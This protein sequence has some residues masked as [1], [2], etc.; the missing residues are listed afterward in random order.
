M[1]CRMA[2]KC[3]WMGVAMVL[4]E[5]RWCYGCWEQERIAL[6]Q[7][8]P[9]F[10]SSLT[11]QN[12]ADA[13]EGSDCCQ[14]E[15]VEC[16]STTGRVT[17]LSLNNTRDLISGK[18][19]LNASLFLA[20]EELTSLYLMGNLIL[21]CETEGFERLSARLSNL[22]VLDLSYNFFNESI[23]PSLNGFSSLKSL[24][25]GYN[26]FTL[27]I[28][29]QDLPNFENLEDLFLDKISLNNSF[30]QRV[31]VMT[32]LKV[33]SLSGCG[34]TGLLP[35]AQ[36]LCELIN[37]QMLDVS[38]NDLR[39]TLPWCLVNLIS[40]QQLDLSF[41]QFAGNISHS[42]LKNL[43]SLVDLKLSNNHFQ[44]PFSL[45]PFF[46]HSNLRQINGQYNEIYVETELH[47]SPKFQL[48]SILLSG[49]GNCGPFPN[50]LYHQHDLQIVDLSNMTLK[51]SF[52]NWLLTN[53]TRL[54]V[55]H[56]VNNSLSGHLELPFH[57]HINLS[58]LDISNNNFHNHIPLEIGSYF[59]KLIYLNMSKNGF[60]GSIPSSFGN[61]SSLEILD[62]S[63][64]QLS[65]IIPELLAIGCFS[66][67]TLILSNNNLQGHIF[68]EHFNLT[69]LWW[70][71]LDGNNFSGRISNCLSTSSLSILDLRDNHL[72]GR[73]PGWIGNLSYL[74][75]LVISNNHLE[76]PI[77]LEFC[78]LQYLEVLDLSKNNVSGNLPSCFRPSSIIH[79]YLSDNG[80]EGPMTNALS[81]GRFLTT[82]DLSNNRMTGRIPNW[83]GGLPALK[84]LLLKNNNFDGEI[85]LQMCHQFYRLSLIDLS[86]NNLSG[87]IPSCL[88][89]DLS[90]EPP[91]PNDVSFLDP[92]FFPFFEPKRPL[93]F[94]TKHFSY[95]YQGKILRL[96]SGLDLSCNKLTGNIP[97][98]IGYLSR[99]HVLNLSYNG[100]TGPIPSTFSN[101][102]QIESLDLSYNNLEGNIPFQLTKLNYLSV[103]SVAHN[104]LSGM[105]P[106]RTQQFATFDASSYEGNPY[107]CGLPLPK[108]CTSSTESLSWPRASAMDEDSGFLDMNVFY[109]SFTVSYIFV[110]LGIFLVL[111]INPQ[112]RHAW[113]Y[114]IEMCISSCQYSV[115]SNMPKL[116]CHGNK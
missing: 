39:G 16:S 79:V 57:P 102:E 104:N 90:A 112:W 2:P 14:W 56:L 23:L 100:F 70:L 114:L 97:S 28:Q 3:V 58:E 95:S 78:Q 4:A 93:K 105:T 37:L 43:T 53:N 82:F 24:N 61:M 11:L 42:P 54:E 52:P 1:L 92:P 98:E 26:Q 46:Y 94:T 55:L 75:D 35:N 40:L 31:R 101:L 59:P 108:N 32:S 27:P 5:M 50:F 47:S 13:E 6:L 29:A 38:N 48:N 84:F 63:D 76:G 49:C 25:L 103:F 77:P 67:D 41:N 22:E 36:G 44:I 45:G 116:F 20:F 17:Q 72:S 19:Y 12:W 91:D 107:L 113:F 68:S 34:L 30:L 85:P 111:C 73:I 10:D 110:L 109:A 81:D 71:Q 89:P 115:V 74:R 88:T 51:G 83:I 96:M 8:K 64:N 69:K 99:S 21:G 60:D 15:R 106:E 87:P 33:L 66:L 18:W 86:H 80:I 7:L 9:F 65:G 62:L